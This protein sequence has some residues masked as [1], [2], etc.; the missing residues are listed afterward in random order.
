MMIWKLARG[1][2][3]QDLLLLPPS[4]PAAHD[5]YLVRPNGFQDALRIDVMLLCKDFGLGAISAAWYLFSTA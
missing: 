4:S 1:D 5:A 2:L 3:L